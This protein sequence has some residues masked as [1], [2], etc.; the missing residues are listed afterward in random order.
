MTPVRLRGERGAVLPLVAVVLMGLLAITALVIDGGL[1]FAERR[2]LQGLADGAAR[3][4]AM[5]LD[6][7][8]LRDQDAVRLEPDAAR[9]AARDYLRAAGF[10]GHV[11]V[12]A[13]TLRVTVELV[14]DRPTV[15]MGL[16]GIRSVRTEAHSVARPRAG[17]DGPEGT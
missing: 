8:G 16:L 17:I 9:Q 14:Q 4:G 6:I 15:M 1:L 12:A 7:A 11:S 5:S 2:D 3:A 13:D 10:D